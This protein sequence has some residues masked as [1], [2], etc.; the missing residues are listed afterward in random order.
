MLDTILRS[1]QISVLIIMVLM[2]LAYIG[3]YA[4]LTRLEHAESVAY[5]RSVELSIEFE[6]IKHSSR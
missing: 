2:A 4:L 6:T 3:Y 5:V 1:R